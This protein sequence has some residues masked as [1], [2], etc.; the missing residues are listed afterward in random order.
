MK[1]DILV[2]KLQAPSAK[3]A[4]RVIHSR[5]TLSTLHALAV[6]LPHLTLTVQEPATCGIIQGGGHSFSG[7][8]PRICMAQNF[9]GL[10]PRRIYSWAL[11]A[12]GSRK[13]RSNG[14]SLFLQTGGW[15]TVVNVQLL[16]TFIRLPHFTP[17]EQ[18]TRPS[19]CYRQKTSEFIDRPKST[20][21]S[22]I[23]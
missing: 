1:D 13:H 23:G 4:W 22:A 7:L 21:R 16:F 3:S 2:R 20:L 6:G 18:V 8:L 12:L 5:P 15:L 11:S 10:L 19:F 9:S 14:S 17:S